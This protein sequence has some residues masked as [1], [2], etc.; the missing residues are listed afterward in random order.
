[1]AALKQRAEDIKHIFFNENVWIPIQMS[2]KFVP[3]CPID[4]K[5]ALVQMVAWH[6]TGDK[7]ISG[8]KIVYWCKYTSIGLNELRG[9]NHIPYHKTETCYSL[10]N[11]KLL[12]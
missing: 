9:I 2:L 3:K 4:N 5:T 1:M 7:P 10:M 6:R 12:M 11:K 8:R